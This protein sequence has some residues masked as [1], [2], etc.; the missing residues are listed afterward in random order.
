MHL[1]TN[2]DVAFDDHIFGSDTDVA[3]GE[4]FDS[5]SELVCPFYHRRKADAQ[6]I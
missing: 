4:R 5:A 2:P 1:L 3:D 6:C